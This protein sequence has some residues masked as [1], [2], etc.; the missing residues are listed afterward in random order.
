MI[1]DI[2]I[3]ASTLTFFEAIKTSTI[4]IGSIPSPG[5]IFIRG[6]AQLTRLPAAHG[7]WD[8]TRKQDQTSD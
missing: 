7:P 2:P 1:C 6:E 5:I 3:L 8:L 4:P